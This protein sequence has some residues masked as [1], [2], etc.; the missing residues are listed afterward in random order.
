M[1]KSGLTFAVETAEDFG[2]RAVNKLVPLESTARILEEAERRGWR[3]AKLYF[4]LGLPPSQH[5]RDEVAEILDYIDELRSRTRMRYNVAVATSV[6]KPHT[7]FQWERQLS[8]AE[9]L[10]KI[11]RLKRGLRNRKIKLGYQAPF[12]SLLEGL[13]ARGDRSV[14]DIIEDIECSRSRLNV[15]HFRGTE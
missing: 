7:P 8:E 4:M 10:Q 13:I 11:M 15:K 1:R 6:P 9:A 14:A 12:Q 5:S 2:Q 3:H